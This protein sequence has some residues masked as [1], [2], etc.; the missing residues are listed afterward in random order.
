MT[1]RG[2][3][4][5]HS[6]L[7][8]VFLFLSVLNSPALFSQTRLINVKVFG[9]EEL[10]LRPGWEMVTERCLSQVSSEFEREFG[11]KFVI[12]EYGIW[13]SDDNAHSLEMLAEQ[14]DAQVNKGPAD[15]L[16]AF[17]GQKNLDPSYFG[18]SLFKEGLIL[19]QYSE[20]TPVLV[21]ALTHEFG[22]LFGAVHVPDPESVMDY[23][24][25]SSRFDAL[26][27]QAVELSRERPFKTIDFP[28]PKKNRARA[29]ELY[30]KICEV[31]RIA[32]AR[33]K[34]GWETAAGIKG[35]RGENGVRDT[36]YLDDAHLMLAQLYLENKE[37]DKT[38]ATCRVALTINPDN[39]ETENLLGVAFRRMGR[40]EEAIE[41]YRDILKQRPRHS[42]VYYNL[43][44]AYSKRGESEAALA[45]YQKACELKPNFAE[46]HNNL[47]DIYL[48]LNRVE[49]AERELHKAISLYDG[50][51]LALS[52]LAEVMCRKKD[53]PSALAE[54]ERAVAL[55]PEIPDPYNIIGNIHHQQGRNE[56]AVKDYFKALSL[57][58]G[59]EKAYF[60]LGVC[61][62]DQ[63]H[64]EKGKE[65]LLK[66]LE[67]DKSFAEAHASLGYCL[68]REN[69]PAAAIS[70]IAL[71]QKL[72]FRPAK[73]YINL[74]SAYLQNGEI[75][76]AVA[77]AEK[78]I[79]LDPDSALAYNNLGV[80]RAKKGMVEDA[81]RHFQK[82][83][84]LDR[85]GKDARVNLGNIY[86]QSGRLDRALEL[87]SQ[88]VKLDPTDGTIYNNMAVIYFQ[89]KDYSLSLEYVKRAQSLGF[90]VHP[91]F[92]QELLKKID[93]TGNQLPNF[94]GQ[95]SLRV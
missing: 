79:E 43:G 74:S 80:A 46:A 86:F 84:D 48:R 29:I 89:K 19:S 60:N 45:A 62:L 71:A 26:N 35:V 78:A 95:D 14:L 88:A 21:R 61:Y 41:K 54:A 91:D 59:Y 24:V 38:I 4:K 15:I 44:I 53:Y 27:I 58:P 57:D 52:N 30:E 83:V 49:D 55:N 47:G 13:D 67:I 2:R 20:D 69:K 85:Q 39:I 92:L 23:F 1:D 90:K 65:Y 9:D 50:Y 64:P 37:Y 82:A 17:T 6:N 11:I 73:T 33:A 72:G 77:A 56:E 8:T 75:D 12:E 3:A 16:L 42:R 36:F 68:I 81:V 66:A 63:D 34:A 25:Q 10:R 7:I 40:T 93:K 32:R 76:Q 31:I 87:Y 18:Y 28:I 94:P 22:H 5:E 70:E 51:A